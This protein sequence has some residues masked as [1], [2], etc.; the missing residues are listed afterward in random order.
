MSF[1]T[2]ILNIPTWLLQTLVFIVMCILVIFPVGIPVTVDPTTESAFNLIDSLGEN[3]VILI[4]IDHDPGAAPILIPGEVVISKNALTN[5]VKIIYVTLR[6]AGIS[7][8]QQVVEE[9]ELE[10]RGFSYGEDYV[11]LGYV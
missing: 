11:F 10:K 3:D 2:K 9:A 5:G 4:S 7:F 6:P 1:A 8:F